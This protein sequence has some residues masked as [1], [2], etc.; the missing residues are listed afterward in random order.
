MT[1]VWPDGAI[2]NT[3]LQVTVEPTERT[4]LSAPQVFYFGHLGG[5]SGEAAAGEPFPRVNALD[6][7]AVKRAL[8]TP[9]TVDSR[10]D[11][12]RD[13]RVSALDLAAVKQN[14]GRGL[15]VLHAPLP[16]PSSSATQTTG[17]PSALLREPDGA[18]PA[19]LF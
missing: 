7:A 13:G 9:V 19:G 8:N 10:F 14:L 11:L 5:E 3:W 12:N 6:L 4:G 2:R 16:P 18:G 1:L 17:R 15:P